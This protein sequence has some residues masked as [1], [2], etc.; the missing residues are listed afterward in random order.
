MAEVIKYGI[1][2]DADFFSFLEA[3]VQRILTKE[4]EVLSHMIARC[5]QIKADIVALDEREQNIRALLNLGHTFG[6]AIEAEQGYGNWLHGEAV[7]AGMVIASKLAMLRGDIN[8]TDVERISNLIKAFSLPVSGP[9]SMSAQTY[10]VHMLRDKKAL[11]NNMRFVLPTSIG[12]AQV[13][14]DVSKRLLVTLLD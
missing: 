12:S 11:N 1:I 13:V 7:A 14:S 3:N 4:H 5:C 6:H 8:L 9:D 10:I 2:Y